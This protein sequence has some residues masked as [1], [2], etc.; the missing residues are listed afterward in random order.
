MD[1]FCSAAVAVV[2]VGVLAGCQRTDIGV[3]TSVY[4]D[5]LSGPDVQFAEVLVEAGF[6]VDADTFAEFTRRAADICSDFAS[7]TTFAATVGELG[8]TMSWQQSAALARTSVTRYCPESEAVV[9]TYFRQLE[10]R[11][12]GVAPQAAAP[13]V[14]SPALPLPPSPGPLPPAPRAE[15]GMPCTDVGAVG[16][17]SDGGQFV[18]GSLPDGSIW[19]DTVLLVGIHEADTEC[20]PSIDGGSQ[21]SQGRAVMCVDGTWQIGP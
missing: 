4:I 11:A 12:D 6:D 2:V 14:M 3:P 13:P 15:I 8:A 19:V 20:D 21:T 18:C 7:G 5:G 1:K 9:D 16:I 17:D 10:G